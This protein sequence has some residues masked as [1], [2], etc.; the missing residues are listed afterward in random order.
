VSRATR[1]TRNSCTSCGRSGRCRAERRHRRGEAHRVRELRRG[2]GEP[3]RGR[4]LHAPLRGGGRFRAL[5]R[6]LSRPAPATRSTRPTIRPSR[7]SVGILDILEPGAPL[8]SRANA[9]GHGQPEFVEAQRALCRVGPSGSWPS[10]IARNHAPHRRVADPDAGK[11]LRAGRVRLY[12][13]GLGPS[14]LADTGV[15][16]VPSGAGRRRKRAGPRRLPACGGPRR[17]YGDTGV[18]P[19]KT[20]VQL[21]SRHGR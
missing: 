13:T 14:D 11:A 21:A 1:C 20:N 10:F 7:A 17:P 18:Y 15:D 2:R 16:P 6:R 19:V 4:G 8:S 5:Q 12:T 3:H 9:R